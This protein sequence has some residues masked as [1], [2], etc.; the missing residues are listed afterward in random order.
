MNILDLTD[1]FNFNVDRISETRVKDLVDNLNYALGNVIFEIV[2]QLDLKK[3]KIR[4]AIT[5]DRVFNDNLDPAYMGALKQV[6]ILLR[7]GKT[8]ESEDRDI[9]LDILL[10]NK[11]CQAL[12]QAWFAGR[13]FYGSHDDDDRAF[14]NDDLE[15]M[16]DVVCKKSQSSKLTLTYASCELKREP[17]RFLELFST[18]AIHD[19]FCTILPSTRKQAQLHNGY[20]DQRNSGFR[21]GNHLRRPPYQ[22]FQISTNCP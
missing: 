9:F 14:S 17:N 15:R 3:K 22:L 6:Y 2:H 19:L 7:S 16:Y 20:F 8:I 12:D 18:L 5:F 10:H 1:R 11:M 21:K 13:I 4:P